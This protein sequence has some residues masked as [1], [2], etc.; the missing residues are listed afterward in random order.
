MNKIIL[1]SCMAV[2]ATGCETKNKEGKAVGMAN[3][4]SQYC[5]E[6]GGTLEIVKSEDGER[7][8]CHLPDGA[9]IE[10]WELFRAKDK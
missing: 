8:M 4:A 2:F 1:L 6:V 5:V 7:G 3:P 9:V 10:E